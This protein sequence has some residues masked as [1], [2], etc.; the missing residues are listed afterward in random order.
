M[1]TVAVAE[2]KARLSCYLRQVKAGEEV[3]VTERGAPIARLV[4]VGS[5]GREHDALGELE[6]QGLLRRG[7]GKLPRGFWTMPRPRDDQGSVRR[8]VSEEREGGW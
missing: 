5:G 3:L 7:T 1:K 6:R 4:P 8:A 2:L